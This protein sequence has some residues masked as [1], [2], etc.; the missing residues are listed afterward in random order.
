MGSDGVG[1]HNEW[2]LSTVIVDSV[3]YR[4]HANLLHD[5]RMLDLDKEVRRTTGGWLVTLGI[6]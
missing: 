3:S 5:R 2:I 1:G 4:E 6:G